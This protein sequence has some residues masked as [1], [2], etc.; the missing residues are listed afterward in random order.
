MG[1]FSGGPIFGKCPKTENKP[2]ANFWCQRF[3]KNFGRFPKISPELILS[4]P[5]CSS[6]VNLCVNFT[7]FEHDRL[8][9]VKL[10]L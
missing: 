5:R 4:K 6:N 8:V 1:L 9:Q 2:W 7:C 10:E 3:L